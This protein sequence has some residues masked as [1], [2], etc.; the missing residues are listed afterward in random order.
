MPG[1]CRSFLPHT[2]S[3]IESRDPVIGASALDGD[4]PKHHDVLPSEARQKRREL[5]AGEGQ[6]VESLRAAPE[7]FPPEVTPRTF[8]E[9]PGVAALEIGDGPGNEEDKP[10]AGYR[11]LPTAVVVPAPDLVALQQDP[12]THPGRSPPLECPGRSRH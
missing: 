11:W 10:D 5:R 3:V 8:Y 7:D 6:G 1:S 12:Q 9:H 4:I 2:A